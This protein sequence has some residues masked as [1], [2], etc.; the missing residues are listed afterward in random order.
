MEIGSRDDQA[1]LRDDEAG[2]HDDQAGSRDDQ[3]GS[4]DDQAG[5]RDDQAGS[6]DDQVGYHDDRYYGKFSF[7]GANAPVPPTIH[8]TT[9]ILLKPVPYIFFVFSK[10]KLTLTNN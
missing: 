5:S 3:A 9:C 8:V 2:S 1:G 4:R 6:R 7:T 10:K